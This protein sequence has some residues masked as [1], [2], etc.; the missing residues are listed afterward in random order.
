[1]S[2]PGIA[3]RKPAMA[4][5]VAALFAVCTAVAGTSLATDSSDPPHPALDDCK[6]IWNAS[7]ASQTCTR[8]LAVSTEPGECA[9]AVDCPRTGSYQANT[10][11][12]TGCYLRQTGAN[13]Y[14]YL[15]RNE[16][17]FDP[18]DD[19]ELINCEAILEIAS[20]CAEA[21]NQGED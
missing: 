5:I 7:S 4:T 21:A 9:V 8:N 15:C 20:S 18:E 1:M 19:P 12:E 6:S 16:V 13:S 3:I 2:L 17:F 10:T 14:Q 11:V